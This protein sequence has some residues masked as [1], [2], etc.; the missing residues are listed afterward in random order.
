MKARRMGIAL[1]SK[2][3]Q[4]AIR[5]FLFFAV[6]LIF[7]NTSASGLT[8]A[9]GVTL[10][11]AAAVPDTTH[12]IWSLVGDRTDQLF[13][14]YTMGIH[15]RILRLSWRDFEPSEGIYEEAYASSKHAEIAALTKAGYL[16]IVDLGF[17]DTPLWL[18]RNYT[19]TYYVNQYGFAYSGAGSIDSG[20]ANFIFNAKL[21]EV[22]ARYIDSVFSTFNNSFYGVRLGGGRW[23]ELTFPPNIIGSQTNC[24]WAFD[25]NALAQSPVPYW[26]PGDV[27]NNGEAA[28]FINWYLD[29]LVNYQSW[30]INLV[31]RHF[32]GYIMML[33][34][35]WGVRPGQLEQAIMGNLSGQ[36]SAEIN[37]EI[38]RGFDFARQI[39]AIDDPSV[40]VVTT[41]LDA[42]TSGDNTYDVTRW[43]PVKYLS[44]LVKANPLHLKM[45]GENTGQGNLASM[46][47]SAT[48]MERY[49][50]IG[51]TW[52]RE[53][54]LLTGKYATLEDYSRTIRDF[55]SLV[56][57]AVSTPSRRTQ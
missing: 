2:C 12:Y 31:R 32:D 47:R 34:P 24:Y 5:A 30:Q 42:D 52:Y 36:S 44:A 56:P 9:S 13:Q 4:I 50:L 54:E 45:F 40:V 23:G 7:S 35:S 25:P 33:Y 19:D 16:I 41:W 11:A 53:R 27:S 6:A 10:S 1:R 18:H 38:Q 14:Q 8:L 46:H 49:Q 22:L 57:Q 51:M 48:Q 20:D 28:T 37:G 29:Q 17:H 43:S 55:E 21:K 26:R 39:H 3:V 15:S